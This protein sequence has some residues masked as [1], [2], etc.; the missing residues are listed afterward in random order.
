MKG[1]KIFRNLSTRFLLFGRHLF[2]TPT[3][4]IDSG[5]IYGLDPLLFFSRC[6]NFQK[7]KM[8]LNGILF[9]S[10]NPESKVFSEKQFFTIFIQG[11]G[12]SK[13]YFERKIMMH[14]QKNFETFQKKLF[15]KKLH[16]NSMKGPIA[17]VCK[18][19]RVAQPSI[20]SKKLELPH[21]SI[22]NLESVKFKKGLKLIALNFQILE[23]VDNCQTNNIGP[24][25]Y[26]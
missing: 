20:T 24:E 9:V 21:V 8:H 11:I 17:Q 25:K 6:I 13:Q 5:L 3:G 7:M 2:Q 1:S 4:T 14:S 23:N 18:K 19:R 12:F 16:F 22:K 15:H 26:F 10:Y